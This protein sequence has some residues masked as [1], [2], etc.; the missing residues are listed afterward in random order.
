[1][2]ALYKEYK[3]NDK[4]RIFFVYLREAHPVDKDGVDPEATG[5]DGI[6][7]HRNM[8]D[9]VLAAS[10]CLEGLDLNVP[11]LMD[12]MDGVAEKAYGAHPAATVV[13]D[14]QG[15]VAFHARGP[16]GTQPWKAKRCVEDLLTEPQ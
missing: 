10:K 14:L 15:R 1:M 13:I 11:F 9:R 5:P 16:F 8:E 4:V 12:S 3:N 2:Q 7:R 6:G